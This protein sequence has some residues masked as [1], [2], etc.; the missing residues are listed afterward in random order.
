[1]VITRWPEGQPGV[2]MDDIVIGPFDDQ[3]AA[4]EH[5]QDSVDVEDW[6]TGEAKASGY[7]VDDVFITQDLTRIPS[8]GINAPVFTED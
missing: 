3:I 7:V 8:H 6:V 4:A 2:D 1:M 5:M